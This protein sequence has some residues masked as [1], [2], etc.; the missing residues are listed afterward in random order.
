M[1][2]T[3]YAVTVDGLHSDVVGALVLAGLL[4]EAEKKDEERKLRGQGPDI[5]WII[6]DISTWGNRQT[7]GTFEIGDQYEHTPRR[8][9]G[10]I[11][12]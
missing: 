6:P 10:A 11:I 2:E 3:I 8:P 12:R 4:R 1:E 7:T 5:R 9:C